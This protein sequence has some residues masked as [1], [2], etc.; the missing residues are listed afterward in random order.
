MSDSI[1]TTN[2]PR[3]G[4]SA[5]Q[6]AARIAPRHATP[7]IVF[8]IDGTIA[9]GDHRV[10]LILS[11]PKQWDAYFDLCHDDA[12]IPHM[13]RVL[14]SLERDFVIVF[15]SGRA[16]RSRKKT[17]KW[18]S[19]HGAYSGRTRLHLY[20]REDGDHKNDDVLKIE[21]LAKLRADGFEPVMAFDDRTRVVNAWRTAG[22]PCAQVA[23]GDF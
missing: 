18:L 3:P 15:V 12:P 19:D 10:H 22:I 16:A 5:E 9:N 1:T 23:P 8:D 7:C 14:K 13:L 17:E 11:E 21:L 4:E 6:T 20:M 2:T